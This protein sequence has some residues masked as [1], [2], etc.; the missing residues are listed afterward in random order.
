MTRDSI[1]LDRPDAELRL[2]LA[3]MAYALTALLYS[4]HDFAVLAHQYAVS[5]FYV[6]PPMTIAGLSAAAVLA[7]PAAPLGYIRDI[8]QRRGLGAAMTLLVFCLG[9]TAFSTFKHHLPAWVPFFADPP[10]ADLD[11]ALHF[12]PPWRWTHAVTPPGAAGL[13]GFLYGPV[14]FAQFFG[15]VLFAAFLTR[16][17][18]RIRY[19]I[20]LAGTLILLGTLG[21]IAGASAGP[22]FFDRMQGGA[23][24]ADLAT[25]L[26]AT[27]PGAAMLA[28]S[29]YL[30][31]SYR[32]DTAV[33]G[34]G[35]SAMPSIHVAIAT[36]NAL[37]L[38][39]LNPQLAPI[40]AIFAA[41]ILFGSVYFGWHYA[42]DGYAS[43]LGVALIWWGAGRLARP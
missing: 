43:I 16:D 30:Y 25:C 4:R 26:A 42:L 19:L 2:A 7:R 10:L 24:F 38:R 12:G 6:L 17:R 23:R 34:S 18:L 11:E 28:A 9:V 15:F 3:C 27:R 37:F 21:R 40:G 5:H 32:S 31:A 22:I 1:P 33:F 8:L 35:I 13:L 36:L 41:S 29:D 14:W 20:A 39:A